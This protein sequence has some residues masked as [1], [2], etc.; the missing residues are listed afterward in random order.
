M[1]ESGFGKSPPVPDQTKES[2]IEIL[3]GL[4]VAEKAQ[5]IYD[6]L[7]PEIGCRFVEANVILTIA[8]M[9][10]MADIH[11]VKLDESKIQKIDQLN[12]VIKKSGTR[13]GYPR[14]IDDYSKPVQLSLYNKRFENNAQISESDSDDVYLGKLLGYPSQAVLDSEDHH[15]KHKQGQD[16]PKKLIEF[17]IIS[18]IPEASKYGGAVPDFDYYEEHKDNPEITEYI[19]KAKKILQEFYA[20]DWHQNI[21]KNPDFQQARQYPSKIK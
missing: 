4:E 2:Q 8:G 6:I 16:N 14:K 19:A 17:D 1:D 13:L 9:K 20:S 11:E 15:T 18:S 10:G 7:G 3:S 12:S 5:E 21:S